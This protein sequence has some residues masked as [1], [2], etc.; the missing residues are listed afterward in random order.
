MLGPMSAP[1]SGAKYVSLCGGFVLSLDVLVLALLSSAF[2]LGLFLPL[3]P[4]LV[5]Q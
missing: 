1:G 2:L 4:L 3:P 5:I